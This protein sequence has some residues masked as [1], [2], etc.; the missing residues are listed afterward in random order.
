MWV[1]GAE[2]SLLGESGDLFHVGERG[3]DSSSLWGTE[4]GPEVKEEE[5]EDCLHLV[6]EI[7]GVVSDG[8]E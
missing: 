2:L 5:E 3:G 7:S 6:T 8:T 4:S 1:T